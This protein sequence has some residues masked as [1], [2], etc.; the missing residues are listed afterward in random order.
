MLIIKFADRL[1]NLREV[2]FSSKEKQD[3][4][5]KE[6]YEMYVNLL[7]KNKKEDIFGKIYNIFKLEKDKI[8]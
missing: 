1:N 2:Q 4:F 6:T 7:I 5:R 8:N 3:R